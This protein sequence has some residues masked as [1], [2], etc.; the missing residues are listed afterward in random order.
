MC[1]KPSHKGQT[2]SIRVIG[3]A[4]GGKQLSSECLLKYFVFK[5]EENVSLPGSQL[6]FTKIM[7]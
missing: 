2:T 4:F 6:G 5:T 3:K 1:C 7:F